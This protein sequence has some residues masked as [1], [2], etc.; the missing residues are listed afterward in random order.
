MSKEFAFCAKSCKFVFDE[1]GTFNVFNL[2]RLFKNNNQEE[3]NLDISYLDYDQQVNVLSKIPNFLELYSEVISKSAIM[4]SV[5]CSK[6]NESLIVQIGK[7]FKIEDDI[8]FEDNKV[9]FDVGSCKNLTNKQDPHLVKNVRGAALLSLVQD[10]IEIKQINNTFSIFDVESPIFLHAA[11]EFLY[12]KENAKMV[13]NVLVEW[14]R[15]LDDKT[16]INKKISFAEK[17]A[18]KI[19]KLINIATN[20]S[21]KNSDF[22]YLYNES[23]VKKIGIEDSFYRQKT[24]INLWFVDDQ[25][26]NGWSR[27]LERII[28]VSMINMECVGSV[29]GVSAQIELATIVDKSTAPDLALV[30]LRLSDSDNGV[31]LYNADDLSGFK[32]VE[33]LLSQWAGLPIMIAS[34]SNKLWNMEKAIQKGAV[35]YWRKS[36]E[37]IKE[38]SQ[39]SILTAFD[40]YIQFTEKLSTLLNKMK[41]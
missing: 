14:E 6:V 20:S 29:V 1:D 21:I 5:K 22:S 10:L 9:T 26:A 12:N 13:W 27:L 7:K 34:A 24:K 33:M 19:N 32:V 15:T 3:I 28:S 40:I 16:E 17:E 23:I 2:L 4:A 41:Y 30:D 8:C 31:E 35:S 37:V 36:D 25:H 11:N 38:S 18:I 39:K